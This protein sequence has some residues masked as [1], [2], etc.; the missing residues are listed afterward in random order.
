[1]VVEVVV[2]VVRVGLGCLVR[3]LNR[4]LEV[5]LGVRGVSLAGNLLVLPSVVSTSG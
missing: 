3:R 4:W 5:M 2:V 1:M